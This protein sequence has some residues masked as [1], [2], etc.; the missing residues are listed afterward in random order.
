[1]NLLIITTVVFVLF[2]LVRAI[3]KYIIDCT[4][5]GWFIQ[6][7]WWGIKW[8]SKNWRLFETRGFMAYKIMEE[9]FDEWFESTMDEA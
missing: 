5:L 3:C 6:G 1:M 2:I 4:E 8:M 7:T 9:D